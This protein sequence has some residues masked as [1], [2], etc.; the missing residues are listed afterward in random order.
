MLKRTVIL[1]FIPLFL[2]TIRAKINFAQ[3]V[4][5]KLPLR[6]SGNKNSERDLAYYR[7]Y[8]GIATRD[9]N[10]HPIVA[11]DRSHPY[12][13]FDSSILSPGMTYFIALTAVDTSGNESGYSSE[14]VVSIESSFNSGTPIYHSISPGEEQMYE[15]DVPANQASLEVVL[16]GNNDADRIAGLYWRNLEWFHRKRWCVLYDS[17]H[18]EPRSSWGRCGWKQHNAQVRKGPRWLTKARGYWQC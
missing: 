9:Y 10:S 8:Y 14:I 18:D 4:P 7:V 16:T 3:P 1:F 17:R 5:V 13:E 15:I 12:A 11:V 2:I 6:L